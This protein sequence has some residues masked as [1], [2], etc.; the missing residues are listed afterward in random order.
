MRLRETI[1][2][3][4]AIRFLSTPIST[5]IHE[6]VT[7][8]IRIEKLPVGLANGIFAIDGVRVGNHGLF[9]RRFA[10]FWEG[11]RV[12]PSGVTI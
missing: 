4:S 12:I 5:E 7:F 11:R 2:Y 6:S 1:C 3:R 9:T 8:S 10:G